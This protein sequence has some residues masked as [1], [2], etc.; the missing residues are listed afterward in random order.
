[1][2]AASARPIKRAHG[3][4]TIIRDFDAVV[5]TTGPAH[6]A[7]ID[8]QPYLADLAVGDSRCSTPPGS[9]S[10]ATNMRLLDRGGSPVPGLYVA[11][12]LARGTFGELMGLPQVSEHA[13]LVAAEIIASI[14]EQ[15][16]AVGDGR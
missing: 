9:A 15:A 7:V 12:P 5:V 3:A 2:P 11:G 14:A 10:G 1:M 4:G 8:S 6:N 16:K 13:A